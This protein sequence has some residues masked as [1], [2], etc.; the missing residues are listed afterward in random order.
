M[1]TGGDSTAGGWQRYLLPD[2]SSARPNPCPE[3]IAKHRNPAV[4][5]VR[6]K[7]ITLREQNLT[8]LSARSADMHAPVS[9]RR[10]SVWRRKWSFCSGAGGSVSAAGGK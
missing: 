2:R 7:K 9:A 4:P 1:L 8:V 5:I 10:S 3:K 6:P